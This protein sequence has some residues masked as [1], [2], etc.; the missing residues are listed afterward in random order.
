ML[1]TNWA[2][3]DFKAKILGSF[4]PN[5][6]W[7]SSSKASIKVR[8][9]KAAISYTI[10]DGLCT[11]VRAA[12][13]EDVLAEAAKVQSVAWVVPNFCGQLVRWSQTTTMFCCHL[14]CQQGH[15]FDFTSNLISLQ[16]PLQ[17]KEL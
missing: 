8:S 13:A 7:H 11:N 1:S 6:S 5:A 15:S 2:Q 17:T 4:L 12:A 9:V 3:V 14:D 10:V 16:T